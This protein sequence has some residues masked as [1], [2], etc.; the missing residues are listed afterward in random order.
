MPPEAP[1]DT[2]AGVT[3]NEHGAA[4][5]ETAKFCPLTAMVPFL[6][7]TA[8]LAATENWNVPSPWPLVVPE[9]VIHAVPGDADHVQSRVVLT[10]TLP[11]PPDAGTEAGEP[12]TVTW[13]R[14]GSFGDVADVAVDD[15]QLDEAVA[16]PTSAT[17]TVARRRVSANREG[18]GTPRW[19]ARRGP[20]ER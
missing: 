8:E 5:C 3:A 12:D 14:D 10:D 7:E 13:Q 6:A 2:V 9:S 20:D 16:V 1:T 4:C 17:S 11:P 18:E 15:P 19:R